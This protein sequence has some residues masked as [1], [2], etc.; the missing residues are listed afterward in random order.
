[1]CHNLEPFASYAHGFDHV[2]GTGTP[3]TSSA[4]AEGWLFEATFEAARR[5]GYERLF[6][7]IPADNSG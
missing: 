5:K 4:E 2:G 3:S 1:M 7:F 6:A